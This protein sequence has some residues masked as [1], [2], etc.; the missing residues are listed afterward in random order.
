MLVRI[1]SLFYHSIH[2]FRVEW[3]NNS[4]MLVLGLGTAG[5]RLEV[6]SKPK[7]V[8][9]AECVRKYGAQKSTK[10]FKGV[11][12]DIKNSRNSSCSILIEKRDS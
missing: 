3:I 2:P 6:L 7:L 4:A 8:N 11:L 12:A 5:K 9:L 10:Y 1:V